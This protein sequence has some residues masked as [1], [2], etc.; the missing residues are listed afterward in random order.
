MTP[1]A[2][3]QGITAPAITVVTCEIKHRNNFKMISVLF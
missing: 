2:F 3:F 1:P